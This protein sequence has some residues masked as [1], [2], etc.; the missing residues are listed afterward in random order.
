MKGEVAPFI[1][2]YIRNKSATIGSAGSGLTF[3]AWRH[4]VSETTRLK[5]P[6]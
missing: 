6:V 2:A 3:G 1:T 5:V 4:L